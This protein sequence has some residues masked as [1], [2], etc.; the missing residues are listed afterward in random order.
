[1]NNKTL[2]SACTLVLVFLGLTAGVLYFLYVQKGLPYF[3]YIDSALV[4]LTLATLLLWARTYLVESYALDEFH[5]FFPMDAIIILLWMV[6]FG[7]YFLIG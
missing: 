2:L 3:W 6:M 1:M 4:G 5:D 7:T